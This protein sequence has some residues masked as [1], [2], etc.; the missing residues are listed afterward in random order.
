MV[1]KLNLT[2][3]LAAALMAVVILVVALLFRNELHAA[4]QARMELEEKAQA[5][6]AIDTCLKAGTVSWTKNDVTTVTT[7]QESYVTCLKEKG[8]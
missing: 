1:N 7:H 4:N 6:Q 2:H 5:H 3:L 8:Y